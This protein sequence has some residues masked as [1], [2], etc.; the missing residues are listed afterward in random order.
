[1]I[2]ATKQGLSQTQDWEVRHHGQIPPLRF[3][4]SRP[5]EIISRLI[6]TCGCAHPALIWIWRTL[7][8][9]LQW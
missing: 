6:F 1:M 4:G 8:S 2:L 7:V 3:V 9:P 5:C